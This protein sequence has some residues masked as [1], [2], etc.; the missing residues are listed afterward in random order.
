[1]N[2]YEFKKIG[3]EINVS[4]GLIKRRNFYYLEGEDLTIV[5]GIQKSSYSS[6]Y[7]F[8]LGYVIKILNDKHYPNYTDGKVRLRFEFEMD[9]KTTDIVDIQ[10]ALKDQLISGLM[11]N[12]K[13][14]ISSIT[15]T[16]ALKNLILKE[17]DL[18]YQTTLATKQYLKIE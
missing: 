11:R 14:Y 4:F 6:G 7:Y 16:G 2:T 15:S 3:D 10:D 12:I 18:L 17:L 5:L 1:M 13:H 9:G 8:N